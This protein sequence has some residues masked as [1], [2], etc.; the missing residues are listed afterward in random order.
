MEIGKMITS[1]WHN[2]IFSL[3]VTGQGQ[4]FQK[5]NIGHISDVIRLT[6]F[7][8]DINVQHDNWRLMS[9]MTMT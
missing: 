7:I 3:S 5:V 2:F 6:G 1:V 8:L 4:M 9:S